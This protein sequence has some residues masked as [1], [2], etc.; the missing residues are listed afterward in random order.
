MEQSVTKRPG[1]S[2][3]DSL[4]K[5]NLTSHSILHSSNCTFPSYFWKVKNSG[6]ML[7]LFSS[8]SKVLNPY[9]IY[10][11][12]APILTQHSPQIQ[13]TC[14]PI[15]YHFLNLSRCHFIQDLARRHSRAI[16]SE[17]KVLSDLS[18]PPLSFFKYLAW[19]A[20]LWGQSKTFCFG[21]QAGPLSW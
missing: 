3:G 9:Q 6:V 20:L 7:G 12:S 1:V 21:V 13:S 16:M 18:R 17:F 15:L 11:P 10:L 14:F 5:L 4:T 8:T 2:T 19:S